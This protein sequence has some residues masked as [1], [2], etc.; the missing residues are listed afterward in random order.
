MAS[1]SSLR[2]LVVDDNPDITM[3][4]AAI[5]RLEHIEVHTA[6]DGFVGME[7]AQVKRPQAVVLDIGMPGM[8][9]FELAKR[10]R[11]LPGGDK[12]FIVAISGQRLTTIEDRALAADAG[13][14]RCFTKPAD[15]IKLVALLKKTL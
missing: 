6:N 13:I 5:M 14:D 8:S 1:A 4:L 12:I 11:M 7:L 15:P 9:G 2:V 3:S 10:L